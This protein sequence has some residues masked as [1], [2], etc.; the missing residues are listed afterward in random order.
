MADVS[1]QRRLDGFAAELATLRGQVAA[2]AIVIDLL[3]KAIAHLDGA[4]SEA[5][6]MTLEVAEMDQTEAHGDG[7]TAMALRRIRER[8]GFADR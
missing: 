6:A 8:L 2:Q 5:I 7:E 1:L 3:V 4:S